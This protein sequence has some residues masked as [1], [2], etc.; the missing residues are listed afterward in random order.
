MSRSLMSRRRLSH[1]AWA[2]VLS[3]TVLV[4]GAACDSPRYPPP[5]E[6]RR[7]AVSD[8]IHSVEISDDYRWL[9]EQDAPETRRWIDE[10]NA[11]AELIIGN[12]ELRD[13]LRERLTELMDSD[14]VGGPRRAGE[15]EL[16]TL[17]RRGEP[18]AKIV[19]RPAPAE[20]SAEAGSPIAADG[21]YE[22]VVDPLDISDDGTTSVAIRAISP[23]GRLLAYAI[24]RGGPD[25][26]EIRIRD[27]ETGDDLPNAL[28]LAMRDVTSLYGSVFFLED[29]SGFIYVTRSREIGPRAYLHRIRRSGPEDQDGQENER[30]PL[31]F[32]EDLGP[33]NF[34]SVSSNK[35]PD[36]RWV[37]LYSVQHGWARSDVYLQVIDGPDA[38]EGDIVAIAEGLEGRFSARFVDGELMMQTSYHASNERVVAVDV[39][40]PGEEHWR[41]VI[42]E[43]E[44]VL[45]DYALIGDRFYATYMHDVST[46]IRVYERDGSPVEA[47]QESS[48]LKVPPLHSASI[49]GAG[50]GHARLTLQ[51]FARPAE[52][53][54]VD[55]ATGNRELWQAAQ[56]ADAFNGRD[57]EVE[58]VHA[59]SK[60]GTRVP[61]FVVH[62][63]D[64]ELDGDNPTLLYG[65]GGFT[66]PLMPSFNAAAAV[67]VERGG[68]YAVATLR[69]D[70]EFGETWIAAACS[71]TSRTSSTTSSPPPST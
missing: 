71:R 40:Q 53:Y 30:D 37:R 54:D 59:T 34:L 13:E 68:V 46:V 64:T 11:H 39:D 63:S 25:E 23:D 47:L 10:Q 60:D 69:G 58:Q 29:S 49:S 51:S 45:D 7:A 8:I 61:V 52:T 24:R 35:L 57:V 16:F 67:W 66:A 38:T 9:E 27:L 22:V 21:E 5:P 15:A 4:S 65:Y 33:R 41:E 1:R 43:T 28:P 3:A 18:I 20:D 50:A 70:T 55:L 31:L 6:T 32:G 42:A 14:D 17:R 36:G 2:R 56:I 48:A 26:V 19:R 62:R 44:D 12:R